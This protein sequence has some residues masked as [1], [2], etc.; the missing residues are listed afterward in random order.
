[1]M[2]WAWPVLP[3][4]AFSFCLDWNDLDL[5]HWPLPCFAILGCCYLCWIVQC[6][7]SLVQTGCLDGIYAGG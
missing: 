1:M 7:E 3:V 5:V 4:P 2:G 6:S